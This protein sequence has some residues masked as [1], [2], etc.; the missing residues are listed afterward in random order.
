MKLNYKTN[1]FLVIAYVILAIAFVF[2]FINLTKV[3]IQLE[4]ETKDKEFYRK[5][6]FLNNEE[7][8]L[9]AETIEEIVSYNNN[10]QRLVNCKSYQDIDKIEKS[11]DSLYSTYV[12]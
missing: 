1:K 11:L 12:K 6:M 3:Q 4:K 8:C 2:N 10:Y 5:V 7:N 9:Y